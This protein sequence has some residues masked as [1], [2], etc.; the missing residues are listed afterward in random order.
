MPTVEDRGGRRSVQTRAETR[1]ELKR[2]MPLRPPMPTTD[3]VVVG[4]GP[5]GSTLAYHLAKKGWSVTLLE[6]H[7]LIGRPVQCAGLVS[8]RVLDMAGTSKM[9]QRPMGGA[10]V[11]GPSMGKIEFAAGETRAHVISREMLDFLL[12]ERAA[13]AGV[14][15]LTGWKFKDIRE[16][17]NTPDG[18]VV[19]GAE[20]PT[21]PAE[22]TTRLLVGSDGVA[23]TVARKLR[24]RRPIE[25]LPAFEADLPFRDAP[26]DQVEIYL[27][28]DLA[29]GFFGW[30][31]PD[32]EGNVRV[33]VGL[34]A[35]N[36]LLALDGYRELVR[37][38]ERRYG[39][40]LPSPIRTIVSGIPVGQIPVISTDHGL[41]VGDAAAQ[42]KPL[43]GGGIFTGMRAAELAAGVASAALEEGNLS[44]QRLREYDRQWAHEM[45]DEM[46][47]ALFFRRLFVQLSDADLDRLL[48]VL[49]ESKLI[50]T[51]VAF[52][53]IDFPTLTIRE[54]LGQSPSL[55]HLFPKA[56]SAFFRRKRGLAPDVLAG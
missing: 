20:S 21:G 47:R 8:Q 55:V 25:I 43:S 22:L 27:G 34:N 44:A 10:I 19:L 52:G 4:A 45:G 40:K 51:I 3:V 5:S 16:R 17:P 12:A 32:G 9:V 41:L 2:E 48:E 30:S 36:G 31:I 18:K 33:G 54:L 28:R 14:Q 29:P 23:S 39:R 24:L 38:M 15:V 42:V 49:K 7:P 11:W 56:L 37:R 53:D 35:R 26:Q 46:D 50:S 1:K 6:E 13:R